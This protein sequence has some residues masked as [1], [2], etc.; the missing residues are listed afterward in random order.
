MSRPSRVVQLA[1]ALSAVSCFSALAAEQCEP[2][3]QM[4]FNEPLD[5]ALWN[6]A[7]GD[8]CALHLCGWGNNEQQV[9][10]PN[11]VEV[12]DG[13]LKIKAAVDDDGTIRSGKITPAGK[14]ATRFGRIEARVNVQ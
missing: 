2:Q 1:A 9:Y 12:S 13:R 11:H 10:D 5:S 8:G 7:E 4:E 14:F 3:W 6:Y